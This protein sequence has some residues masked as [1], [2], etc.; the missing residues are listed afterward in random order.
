VCLDMLRARKA[1]PEETQPS[2]V[3][4]PVDETD[5]EQDALLA[6]SVGLA[7]LVVL[8]ELAPAERVAYV[9][10]DM[11]DLPFDEIA[12]IV[13]RSA[14]ATR[15]L[16]SRA[17]RRVQRGGTVSDPDR[18]RQRE[19]VEAFLAASRKGDFD[20]LIA[21]LD[22]DVVLRVDEVLAPSE[23]AR[24]IRG[25]ATVAKQALMFSGRA[26]ST[27]PVLVNGAVGLAW[28]QDGQPA[29]AF[30]FT[31]GNLKIVEI[32]I[33]A[34]PDRLRRLDLAGLDDLRAP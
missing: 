1:R 32:E 34:D 9:L 3:P 19:I 10:H 11:F 5:A 12:P 33:I 6:D 30:D 22:P 16:A 17:R 13:G 26:E 23:A 29:I 7:L 2:H 8:E 27:R 18:A 20:A 31:V 15:Q 24:E 25:A 28:F 14:D 4:E 21:V